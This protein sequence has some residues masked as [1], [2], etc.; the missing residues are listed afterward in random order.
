MDKAILKSLEFNEKIKYRIMYLY[1]MAFILSAFLFASLD[2][3]IDGIFRIA[4]SPTL[5]LT[6]YLIV[7]GIGASLLN[8]GILMMFTIFIASRSNA[9]MNGPLIA[10]IFTVG[11]FAFFGKN[12]FNI[13]GILLGVY[14]FSRIQK[15][16]FT[17]YIIIAFFGTA[18][19]PLVS[20]VSFGMGFS[21]LTG[22][23]L[24]TVTGVFIGLILPPL[25]S[26]FV[27][28]HQGFN[29]YNIGF[30]AGIVGMIFMSVFRLTGYDHALK[31]ITA[32]ETNINLLILLIFYFLSMI[33]VGLFSSKKG[34]LEYPKLL[35]NPG[36]LVTD[37]VS[38]HGFST[39]ILN[40]GVLGL[41]GIIIVLILKGPI[42]GP[43]IGGIFTLVGFGTF[44]KHPINTLPVMIGVVFSAII[45]GLSISSTGLLLTVLF[46]STLAPISGH[47]GYL[48]GILAG[49]LHLSLVSNLGSLHGGMNLYNNG[50]SG[51]FVAAFLVPLFESYKKERDL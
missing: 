9:L 19:S 39:S 8:S 28:F 40:M 14:I 18:L 48:A 33:S 11:G 30:T 12:I 49:F 27:R 42:N 17:K 38:L 46:A 31:Q 37:F 45:A 36:R 10:A 29:L 43:I 4:M 25:A 5:L 47:Y 16:H 50:F 41:L 34:L 1:S 44:G 24:G 26:S 3:I 21:T 2:L 23:L 35:K 20:Q 6:D 51:G 32:S 22:V 15:D 13:Q 7:G